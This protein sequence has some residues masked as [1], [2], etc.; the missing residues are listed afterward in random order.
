MTVHVTQEDINSGIRTNCDSCPIAI[1]MHRILG[2]P[3]EVV[4]HSAYIGSIGNCR[5]VSIPRVATTFIQ[6]FDGHRP[7]SPFSFDIDLESK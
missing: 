2:E 7:V 6:D 1:A 4:W 5:T 3:V